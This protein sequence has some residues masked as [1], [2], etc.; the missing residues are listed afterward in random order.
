MTH[1]KY[2]QFRFGA[3]LSYLAIAVNIF[4]GIVYTPWMIDT[5]G[6]SDYGLYTLANSLISLF[7]IDVG[8]GT[9]ASRYIAKYRAENR[10]E[11]IPGL[12]SA[13]YKLYLIIDAVILT[14]LMILFFSIDA[15]YVNLTASE[16]TRF[17]VV[18]AI[19]GVYS[20][21]IFP[22]TTFNG[23]LNAY[24][25]FIPLKV[26]DMV[27]RIGSVLL[28]I[29]ALWMGLGLY[30]LVV[31]QAASGCIANLIKLNYVQRLTAFRFT[32]HDRG[33]YR[34]IFNI[35]FWSCI[36]GLAQRLIFNI[37]PTILAMTVP[38]ASKAIA[39][40]G[41]VSTIEGYCYIFTTAINGMFLSKISRILQKSNS[42]KEL[43]TLAINV[44]RF[45]FA[46][47][48]LI[49]LG[50]A[51]IGKEFLYLW[52]GPGFELAYYGVLFVTIPG[53][54]FNALQIFNTTMIARDMVKDQA[55]IQIAMGI[56]NVI[57]SFVFSHIWGVVGAT[58]S[59][60]VA[61]CFRVVMTLVLIRKK[62][63]MDIALYIK[64]CYLRMGAAVLLTGIISS[65]FLQYIGDGSWL[66][67]F[68]KVM[69]IVMV[70]CITQIT[71]GLSRH[72]RKLMRYK[73][74]HTK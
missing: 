36:Y 1:K 7:L 54:F 10:E 18:F 22:C 62:L 53:L 5:I 25:Q 64:N 51:Q 11:L 74:L 32:K 46:L 33:I 40:F 13:V 57:L 23:I 28:T 39:V 43:N 67:F 34:A 42:E 30:S 19:E 55:L 35:S 20:I 63:K 2:N 21:I 44:G 26:A 60:F 27:Q 48:G 71:I 29:A 68:I 52:M 38:D 17:K 24:E 14:A 4:W 61:Y 16:L 49:V 8:L 50:F 69:V 66:L 12:L 72:E 45:Q 59:I 15:I 41:V 6:Q 70:Y 9:A 65:F 56:L 73:F 47:N 31:I 58:L 3:I 37:I